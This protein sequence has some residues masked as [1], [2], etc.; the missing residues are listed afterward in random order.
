M[1]NGKT[2]N[3]NHLVNVLYVPRLKYDLFSG[4]VAF[5][6]GLEMQSTS[7]TCEL[8][9]KGHTIATG[10]RQGKLSVMQF[11]DEEPPWSI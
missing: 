2:W 7:S 6:K 11:A 10:I 4:G 5:D 3:E 1:F 8:M 9:K